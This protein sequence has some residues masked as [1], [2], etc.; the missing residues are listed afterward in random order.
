M[1]PL[2]E[3]GEGEGGGVLKHQ[4]GC[5]ALLYLRECTQLP[6]DQVYHHMA[7]SE[8]VPLPDHHI[9]LLLMEIGHC[10]RLSWRRGVHGQHCRAVLVLAS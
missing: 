10:A 5:A 1:I 7:T 9:P 6:T 3:G 2:S 8:M 4:W